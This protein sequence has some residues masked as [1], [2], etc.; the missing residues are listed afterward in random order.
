[1]A[2]KICS[3]CKK[4]LSIDQFNKDP[5]RSDGYR[6]IFKSCLSTYQKKVVEIKTEKQEQQTRSKIKK[7]CSYIE[8][9]KPET[10][11]F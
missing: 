3:D 5:N 8:I 2:T 6:N 7:K 9:E 10:E 1:M 11:F 4:E